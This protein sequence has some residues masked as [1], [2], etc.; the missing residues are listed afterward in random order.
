MAIAKLFAF[1]PNAKN[2]NYTT[3]NLL[4]FSFHQNYY[5]FIGIDLSKQINTSIPQQ[6]NFTG[7]LQ[8]DD[9]AT[10]LV[11]A[12]KQQKTILNFFLD[13]LIVTE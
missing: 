6:I 1:H 4:D 10:M 8:E 12:E 13:T 2:D 5:K 7:K 11:L 3:G 9:G